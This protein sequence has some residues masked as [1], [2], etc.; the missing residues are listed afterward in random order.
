M[1]IALL[2]MIL[3]GIG[4]PLAPVYFLLLVIIFL[5]GIGQGLVDV[6]AN[7]NLLWVYQSRVGPYMN[8]MHFFFGLGAFLS[9]IIVHKVL[10]MSNGQITWAFWVIAILFLPSLIGLSL[11]PSPIN[12]ELEKQHENQGSRDIWLVVLMMLSFFLYVGAEL[13]FGGWIY[14]YVTE[15][16]IGN[17]ANAAYINSIYWGALT[18]GRFLTVLLSKKIQPSK[19]LF[20]NFILSILSL[21]VLLLW[22]VEL[23]V[24][25]LCSALLGL[26][27]SSVFPTL[28]VLSESRMK[29]TG[30]VTGLFFLGSS[31]GGMLIPMILGQIFEYIGAYQVILALFFIVL[32]GLMAL[33]AVIFA[34]N[35]VGEKAR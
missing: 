9:P 33:L 20:G 16:E 30:R 35:R 4:I 32:F 6:G 5:F 24:V 17:E 29:I 19:I 26:G 3:M 23:I 2:L 25:W 11:L 7:I 14:S 27:F 10:G 15:L 22:P 18:L 28:L 13:G 31:V 8:G 21:A 12:P 1:L 34:S